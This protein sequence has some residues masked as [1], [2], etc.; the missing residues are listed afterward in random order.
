VERTAFVYG[1]DVVDIPIKPFGRAEGLLAPRRLVLDRMLAAAAQEAGA[2]LH[3][4]VTFEA[5][6]RKP[7]GRVDGALLRVDRETVRVCGDIV[8]GADGR[9]S[10]VAQAVA[11]PTLVESQARAATCFGYFDGLPNEGYRW[12]YDAG[13]AAGVIP[14]NGGQ[15]CVFV[16]CPPERLRQHLAGGAAEGMAGV[17][18]RW[19]ENAAGLVRR[20]GQAARFRRFAGAPGFLRAVAGPGWALVGDAGYFKDPSTAHGITDAFLDAQRLASA[21][22]ASP[23]DGASYQ[24]RRDAHARP[25]FDVTQSIASFDW[26]LTGLRALHMR[27][28]ECMKAEANDLLSGMR[29]LA[30]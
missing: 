4:G 21:L 5:V 6:T 30:A 23:A 16:S 9:M 24:G 18:A 17:L 29:S 25:F 2:E 3:T 14:T 28:T 20:Q 7:S 26:N 22:Q 8:I 1:D 15:H 12:F 19:D 27:L 11:A 13:I 10:A